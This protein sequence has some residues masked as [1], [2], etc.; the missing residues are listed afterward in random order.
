MATQLTFAEAF[1]YPDDPSGITLAVVLI[2]GRQ[3]IRIAAKVDT[4][5]AVVGAAGVWAHPAAIEV[6]S[7]N[8]GKQQFC[9]RDMTPPWR[10]WRRCRWTRRQTSAG[11]WN[12]T[13][14]GELRSRT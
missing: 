9:K 3:A 10:F 1:S 8:P 5:A 2:Y 7:S 14:M 12:I 13:V 11:S 4:G 6:A